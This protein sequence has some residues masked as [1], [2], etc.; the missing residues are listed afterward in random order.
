MPNHVTNHLTVEGSTAEVNR[1]LAK[2]GEGAP[3]QRIGDPAEFSFYPFVPYPDDVNQ[4][5]CSHRHNYLNYTEDDLKCWYPWNITFWGTKWG[6]YDVSIDHSPGEPDLVVLA[7]AGLEEEPDRKTVIVM[8]DTAWSPPVPVIEAISKQ[9]P[10]L[11]LTHEWACEG[12][13]TQGRSIYVNGKLR[14]EI[15][16][17]YGDDATPEF[18]EMHKR[19]RGADPRWCR[20]CE[21]N[22][23]HCTCAVP[24]SAR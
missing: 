20:E 6:A 22:Y 19:L 14:S 10:T 18:V 23:D 2:A 24:M 9:F 17:D 11:H 15:H 3:G 1:F 12:G 7:R 13:Q 8:F 5:G 4:E 21:E 16:F